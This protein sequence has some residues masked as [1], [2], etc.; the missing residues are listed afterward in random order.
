[1]RETSCSER[2]HD[3]QGTARRELGDEHGSVGAV[4]REA[5]LCRGVWVEVADATVTRREDDRHATAAYARADV[6]T[7]C[8]RMSRGNAT[9]Q[10]S[11]IPGRHASHNPGGL[12][13]TTQRNGRRLHGQRQFEA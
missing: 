13:M 9:Y 1:M 12:E 2:G 6:S 10:G 3:V 5:L 11:R 7:H 4:V 8:R